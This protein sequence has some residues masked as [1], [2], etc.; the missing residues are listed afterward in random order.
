[1]SAARLLT[2]R[3]M[4]EPADK[5]DPDAGSLVWESEKGPMGIDVRIWREMSG[6]LDVWVYVDW[7][8]WHVESISEA[9]DMSRQAGQLAQWLE[10]LAALIDQLEKE[11]QCPARN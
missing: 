5:L 7:E 11:P 4:H 10:E 9:H 3:P 2:G 1:M 6:K 8:E